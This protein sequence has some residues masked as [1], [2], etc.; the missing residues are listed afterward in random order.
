[1]YISLGYDIV[2]IVEDGAAAQI[3]QDIFISDFVPL[4]LGKLTNWHLESRIDIGVHDIMN[5]EG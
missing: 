4:L 3:G 1:M 5:W 2:F